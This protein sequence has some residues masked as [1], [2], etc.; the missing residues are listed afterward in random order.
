MEFAEE[1]L[2]H[3]LVAVPIPLLIEVFA[4]R[5][6]TPIAR[7]MLLAASILAFLAIFWLSY[8]F[9]CVGCT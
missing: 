2:Y 1:A 6:R 8:F 7:T 5:A 4:F 9:F 3:A